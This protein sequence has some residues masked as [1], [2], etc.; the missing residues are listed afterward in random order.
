MTTRFVSIY[1]H[2]VVRVEMKPSDVDGVARWLQRALA[3]VTDPVQRK[4]RSR[5]LK[6]HKLCCLAFARAYGLIDQWEIHQKESIWKPWVDFE[7]GRKKIRIV[8]VASFDAGKQPCFGRRLVGFVT[9]KDFERKHDAYVLCSWY[10]PWVDI[11]GWIDR[12][13]LAA[14]ASG[15]KMRVEESYVRPMREWHTL[16]KQRVV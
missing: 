14:Y 12:E 10:A 9:N 1:G 15:W 6:P 13:S 7:V 16:E 4:R 2:P 5:E 8:S 11:V 3:E